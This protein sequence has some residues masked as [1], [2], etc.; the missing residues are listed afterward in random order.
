MQQFTD[1]LWTV[2]N[3]YYHAF[4][5][6]LPKLALA[7]FLLF[8]FVFI[9]RQIRRWLMPRLLRNSDDDLLTGFL[10]DV[11]YW[12]AL[13]IGVSVALGTLGLDGAVTKL[14]AGAGL[15]AFILGF[16]LKD[17]GENFLAGILLAFKRP[18]KIGDLVE[19]QGVKG[20]IIDMNLRE[21]II[22][23]PDGKDVFVPNGGILK[24]PLYNYSV[25]DFLRLEFGV[26][27]DKREDH[28]QA[29]RLIESTLKTTNGVLND[30]RHEPKASIEETASNSLC[31]NVSFW[32]HS[33]EAETDS[34]KIKTEAIQNVLSTLEENGFSLDPEST[35][36][37]SK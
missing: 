36:S 28:K 22:K 34:P 10:A 14:L 23:S 1:D 8:L 13:I 16:A 24:N 21:T 17:I 4:V 7:L 15:S 6:I 9:A 20:R 31:V 29:I 35:D 18:Y 32:I 33:P 37:K 3:G 27:L 26:N 2:L 25:D 30:A 19:T 5:E 11:G 12:I